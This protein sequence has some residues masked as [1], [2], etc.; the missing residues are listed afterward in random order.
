MAPEILKN[1]NRILRSSGFS[2]RNSSRIW[3]RI[4]S[5]FLEQ[6]YLIN[7]ASKFQTNVWAVHVKVALIPNFLSFERVGSKINS[8]K[9]GKFQNSELVKAWCESLN[10]CINFVFI[11][12]MINNSKFLCLVIALVRFPY[13]QKQQTYRP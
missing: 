13:P 12:I 10:S 11:S 6:T 8:T 2:D 3:I 5:E 7:C 9:F 4:P 1:C